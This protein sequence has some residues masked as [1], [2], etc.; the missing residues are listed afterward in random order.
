MSTL[1]SV[2]PSTG[3][4]GAGL[5]TLDLN[6]EGVLDWNSFTFSAKDLKGLAATCK[7]SSRGRTAHLRISHQT[8][9]TQS[10]S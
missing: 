5:V 1:G 7:S 3:L 4:L 6:R 2:T 8:G 10:P 9:T